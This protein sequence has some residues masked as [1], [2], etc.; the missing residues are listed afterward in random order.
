MH[1][2]SICHIRSLSAMFSRAGQGVKGNGL[3]PV[4]PW[5]HLSE[6]NQPLAHSVP[7]LSFL[8]ASFQEQYR[9]LK[10]GVLQKGR[11]DVNFAIARMPCIGSPA[12]LNILLL[13]PV[14][15]PPI[16]EMRKC[17]QAPSLFFSS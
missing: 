8:Q 3:I 5:K 6:H 2:F 9:R 16:S 10:H 7:A 14:R 4:C 11:R 13:I 15:R 1:V 17:R 12:R